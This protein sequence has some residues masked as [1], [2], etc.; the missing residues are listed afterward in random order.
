MP[1]TLYVRQLNDVIHDK[2][3]D[4]SQKQGV[5]VGSI[6]EEAVGD[7]MKQK[8][9]IPSK[10]H[11][12][13]YSDKDSLLN[14]LRKMEESGPFLAIGEVRAV[15]AGHD[16]RFVDPAAVAG[17]EPWYQVVELTLDGRGDQTPPLVAL[18]P[19]SDP[20]AS[21]RRRRAGAVR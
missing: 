10:H 20:T 4:L 17:S 12:I 18:S 1:R 5:T 7:W 8:H 3:N 21:G 11:L 13:L 9:D 6:I 16:Y 19:N 14:F 2:L 15:G